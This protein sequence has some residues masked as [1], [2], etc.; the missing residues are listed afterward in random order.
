MYHALHESGHR[1]RYILQDCV[2]PAHNAE[3]FIS[4]VEKELKI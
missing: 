3:E 4:Y 1:D 2:V